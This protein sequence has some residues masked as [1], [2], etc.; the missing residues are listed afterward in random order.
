MS[1]KPVV[2]VVRPDKLD[3]LKAQFPADMALARHNIAE[4][5][6][7]DGKA[8][9]T[10]MLG[11]YKTG[12]LVSTLKTSVFGNSVVLMIGR[13]LKYTKSVFEGAIRHDIKPKG[14]YPL[15]F[16][17][18]GQQFYYGKVDHPGQKARTDI[19]DALKALIMKVAEEEVKS[20]IQT[21]SYR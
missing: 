11:R 6:E 9:V 12:R 10:S 21:R 2:I 14:K 15:G 13:G 17:R 1:S 19:K 7:T 16:K 5:L 18:H 20:I 4:R 3:E 8:L